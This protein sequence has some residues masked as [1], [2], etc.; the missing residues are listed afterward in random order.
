MKTTINKL[1]N[2]TDSPPY[3]K[4]AKLVF[5]YNDE[6]PQLTPERWWAR[7]QCQNLDLSC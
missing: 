2:K 5:V 6:D 7:R 4:R 1:A 3:I